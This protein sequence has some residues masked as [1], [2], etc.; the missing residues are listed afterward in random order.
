[1]LRLG[2]LQLSKLASASL[3]TSAKRIAS[4]KKKRIVKA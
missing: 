1:L 4:D 3:I 2:L